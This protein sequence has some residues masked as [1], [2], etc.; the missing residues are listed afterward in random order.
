M[1]ARLR[2]EDLWRLPL[3]GDDVPGAIAFTPDGNALTYLYSGAGSLVRSLWWHDLR[4]GERRVIAGPPPGTEREETLSHEER[5]RRERTRTSELGVTEFGWATHAQQPTLVV[6]IG[7]KVLV[8]LGADAAELRTLDGVDGASA[9]VGAPDGLHVAFVRDGDLWVSPVDGAPPRRL[10]SDAEPGVFNG[11]AEFIAAEELDRYEGLWWSLD[12]ERLA[13]AHVDERSVPPFAIAH[14]GADAPLHEE[15]RYPFAGGPNAHV[16]LRVAA[17]A[18]GQPAE[19]DLG[20]AEDDYLA[21]V[22]ADPSGGWLV[23]VLPRAQRSIRWLRVSAAGRAKELWTETAKPWIN[24]DSHTRVLNDG[25]ILRATERTGFRHLEL[26]DADGSLR[27][28]LTDGEWMVTNVVH[29]DEQR[30]EVLF[31]GTAD[32]VLE[33]HLYAAPLDVT[34]PTAEPQRLTDEAGWHE[35]V[36]SR[37]AARWADTWSTL[38]RSPSVIVRQRE[39]GEPAI[40]H[41]AELTTASPGRQPPDLLEL[42]A[43]DETTPLHV[44][45]YR[46]SS[47]AASPP[48]CVVWVYGGP[49]QQYVKR[50]WEMTVFPLRQYLA[51]CGVAVLVV[52]NRGSANRGLAFEAPIAGHFGGAEVADQAAAVQQLAATGEIDPSR[53]GITGGSYGGFMTLMAAIQ[54]PD[55]FRAGVAVSPVTAQDGYDTAYTER[56]LGSPQ[57]EPAAY[58][59]SSVLPRASELG[60]SVLLIHAAVDENVHLRHSV[61]L[62]AALQALGRDIELVILPEDRHRARSANGLRTRD[63]RTVLHLL[64]HLGVSL[65]A[66]VAGLGTDTG[67]AG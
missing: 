15:H 66:E 31:M 18:G 58:A 61:R 67:D 33:R 42:V 23:A 26:R 54:R 12:G 52:D 29:V 27:G 6:P 50:A 37:D 16:T 55:L 13:C 53:V 11:L 40:V 43:D 19:I 38:E 44:A 62:V 41:E 21:R 49:H 48:P 47:P 45:L 60:G 10:T 24:L 17:I 63:R 20:M 28:A 64:R 25:S 7:G 5:L 36:V 46:P 1:D 32:G 59:R 3:P 4:T 39:G 65:P 9:V 22:V 14:L 57:D 56:Y 2:L 30:R 35:A 34:Q 8:G 51:Q